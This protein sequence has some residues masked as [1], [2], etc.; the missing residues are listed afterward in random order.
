MRLLVIK[1]LKAR[2]ISVSRIGRQRGRRATLGSGMAPILV[3]EE[4]YELEGDMPNVVFPEGAVV[5]GEELFIFYGGADRVC[6]AASIP[7]RE[8]LRQLLAGVRP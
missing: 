5:L 3:P 4:P 2:A 7:L 6:C 1:S 8:F